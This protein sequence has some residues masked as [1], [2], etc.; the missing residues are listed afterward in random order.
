MLILSIRDTGVGIEPGELPKLFQKFV[1]ASGAGHTAS[2][3]G[4]GLYV[5][6]QLVEGQGGKLWAESAGAGHGT[7]FYLELPSAPVNGAGDQAVM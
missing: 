4:I 5:A 6:K 1:R 3:S 2:G 7:T